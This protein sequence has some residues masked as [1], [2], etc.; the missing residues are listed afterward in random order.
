MQIMT[1]REIADLLKLKEVTIC[2]MVSEGKL[3]GFKLGKSWR[4]DVN[5]IEEW[6]AGMKHG[7]VAK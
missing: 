5:E 1:V 4:F 2:S 7:S 3:P 6:L